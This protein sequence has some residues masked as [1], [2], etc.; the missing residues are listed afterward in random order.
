MGEDTKI[1]WATHTFNAWTGCQKVS[2]ACDSCYAETWARRA[3]RD[4]SQRVR[5]TD[6]NWRQPLKWNAECRKAGTRAQVFTNSL[7]D[8]FD[9]QAPQEWRD[10]ACRDVIEPC[11]SLDWLILTK[12]PQNAPRMVPPEWMERWPPHVWIGASAGTRQE[13]DRNLRHLRALPAA[14]RFLSLEPLLEDLGTIDLTGISWV[15][16]GGESGP[17]AR[18]YHVA[19][20]QQII[21]QCKAAGVP[22]FHKQVGAHPVGFDGHRV[23]LKDRKGGDPEL[24][25]ASLRVRQMPGDR[26]HG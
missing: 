20:A 7:A 17:N 25:P 1:Q 21:D 16:V 2:P 14:I 5:T 8:F 4:F 23:H 26:T 15:I 24:W 19:W 6:S 10:D 9:N 3:G 18:P 12:R 13:L 11:A 22:A